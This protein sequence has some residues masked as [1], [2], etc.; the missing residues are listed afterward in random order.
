VLTVDLENIV[1]YKASDDAQVFSV[2]RLHLLAYSSALPKTPSTRDSPIL[3]TESS[4]SLALLFGFMAPKRQPDLSSVAFDILDPLAVAAEKY[5]VYPAM[6]A[7][8]F[9]MMSVYSKV[10][11]RIHIS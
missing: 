5:R 11:S 10:A 6:A 8:R 9:Y 4:S 2:N 7:C 3:L 1:F